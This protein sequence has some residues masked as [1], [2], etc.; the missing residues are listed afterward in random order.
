MKLSLI[1]ASGSLFAG[2]MAGGNNVPS[3]CISTTIL[4]TTTIYSGQGETKPT[5]G[6]PPSTEKPMLPVAGNGEANSGS[7]PVVPD[8]PPIKNPRPTS[9]A[10]A[11]PDDT[12]QGKTPAEGPNDSGA[13]KPEATPLVVTAGSSRVDLGLAALGLMVLVFI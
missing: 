9:G 4:P 6:S 2:I 3:S 8:G 12:Y 7:H 5:G 1:L 11:S 10:I 13:P